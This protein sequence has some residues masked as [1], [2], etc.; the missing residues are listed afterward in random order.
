MNHLN[1]SI[2]LVASKLRSLLQYM[3][4]SKMSYSS[5]AECHTKIESR[6]CL[7]LRCREL[8]S[9]H[10]SHSDK[11][12]RSAFNQVLILIPISITTR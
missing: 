11:N 10:L 2:I 12:V 5:N 4:N 3:H 8:C 9:M 7:Y 1:R 6:L